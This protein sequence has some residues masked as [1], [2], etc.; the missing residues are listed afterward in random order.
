M[1]DCVACLQV[2]QC[3]VILILG[4]LGKLNPLLAP[5]LALAHFVE[6]FYFVTLLALG[7]LCMTPLPWLVFMFLTSH[8]LVFYPWRFSRLVSR[9]GR[10][11]FP[12]FILCP[13]LSISSVFLL[14][15]PLF[16]LHSYA[17]KLT[18]VVESSWL[19]LL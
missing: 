6:M 18:E 14:F 12:R 13:V 15:L 5:L 17:A 19:R 11:L 1:V 4:G 10:S 2:H 9:I 3:G 16:C 8:A 7:I